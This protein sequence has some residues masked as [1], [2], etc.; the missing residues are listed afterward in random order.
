[1]LFKLVPG[2]F[3]NPITLTEEKKY[4][5]QLEFQLE[6]SGTQEPTEKIGK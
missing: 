6:K 5:G 3:S 2:G 4:E 1:M